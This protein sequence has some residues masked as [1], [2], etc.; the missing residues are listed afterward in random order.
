MSTA[1]VNLLPQEVAE[2]E[3]ARRTAVIAA[4]VLLVFL[5]VLAFIYFSKLAAVNAAREDRDG[6]QQRV[7]ALSAELGQLEQFRLL[8]DQLDER[9]R[10]LVQAMDT[11]VAVARVLNDVALQF[12][13]SA[14][15]RSMA[16][17]LNEEAAVAPPVAPAPDPSATGAPA[18][19]VA[20]AAPAGP[21]RIATPPSTRADAGSAGSIGS[22]TF[23]GYSVERYAPGVESVVL[24]LE[25]VRSFIGSFVTAA[26]DED[27][28]ETEVTSFTGLV[29][30][31]PDAF[32][33]R[34]VEGLPPEA[35]SG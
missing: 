16:L 33:R 19:P 26:Q 8:A 12:P 21:E 14:S 24:Q 11:E 27:I 15:L 30:L 6:E 25:E 18:A 22:I 10:L 28:A 34:Y 31:D 23:E 2:R 7:A 1:R 20:P 32:T 3:Q 4:A 5:A 17:V 13:T 29:D 9:E 35:G